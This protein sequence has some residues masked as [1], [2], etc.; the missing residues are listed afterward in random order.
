MGW[1]EGKGLGAKSQGRLQPVQAKVPKKRQ[2]LGVDSSD[3]EAVISSLHFRVLEVSEVPTGPHSWSED[4]EI[5]V[6]SVDD[7]RVYRWSRWPSSSDTTEL[8]TLALE[9]LQTALLQ[10]DS[11]QALGP[12]IERLETQTR[13]CSEELL[14]EM[15]FYKNSLDK[16]SR[17]AITSA[18][19][20]SNP[21]ENARSGIFM[22]R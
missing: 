14:F 3:T 2:G 20:R 10:P 22:N 1:V 15:L 8:P 9:A 16:R 7:D 4:A 13:Y 11:S 6:A 19:I 21:Y 5:L 17:D 18:R 12:A